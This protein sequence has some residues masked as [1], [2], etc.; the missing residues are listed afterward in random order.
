[1]CLMEAH[2]H[3]SA[4]PHGATQRAHCLAWEHIRDA[5]LSYLPPTFMVLTTRLAAFV[6]LLTLQHV[7]LATSLV[8]E[9]GQMEVSSTC[10]LL[11]HQVA[12][13]ASHGYTAR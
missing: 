8:Q 9:A 4:H 12:P 1:M 3:H 5:S 13:G 2:A 10:V 11:S 7:A 6:V